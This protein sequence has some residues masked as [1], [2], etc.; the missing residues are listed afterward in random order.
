MVA[1]A[2]AN[3]ANVRALGQATIRGISI[4]ISGVPGIWTCAGAQLAEAEKL[5]AEKK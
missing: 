3:T 4:S 2:D 1:T 5:L